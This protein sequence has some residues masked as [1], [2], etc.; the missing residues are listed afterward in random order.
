MKFNL[1]EAIP[2]LRQTPTTLRSLL[3]GLPERWV[4][5]SGDPSFW[6]PYDV[7]G[8]L[9]HGERTDWI[10]RARIILE[11]GESQT[12]DSFDREA[13][14]VESE[15][16]S[17]GDLLDE[18]E[19][20]REQNLVTLEYWQLSEEDLRKKGAH[21]ELGPVTLGHLLATWT[22]HDPE[23]VGDLA[24]KGVHVFHHCRSSR[25]RSIRRFR[26]WR[27]ADGL[28]PRA[29]ASSEALKPAM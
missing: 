29:D 4:E 21:P 26:R 11:V 10:P 25:S 9:V 3:A 13:M 12:F 27:T 28:D 7:V 1:D 14:F 2:V 5:S 16:K 15:G 17:L 18:F 24:L 8:H 6:H 20:L 23:A 19:Q 22:A